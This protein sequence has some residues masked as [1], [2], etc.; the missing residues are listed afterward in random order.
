MFE[1]I[2]GIVVLVAGLALMTFS[3]D[4]AVEH[5][6]CLASALRMSP[7]MVGL[8][9]VSIGT[10]LPEI[11]NSIVSSALGHGNINAG[12]SMRSSLYLQ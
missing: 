12:D 11:V 8:L 1:A 7:L 10:D 9:L 5:S 6:V 4:K 2:V 3:S